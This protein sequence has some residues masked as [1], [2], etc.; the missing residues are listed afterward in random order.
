MTY[1][2][3]QSIADTQLELSHLS[4]Q[5]E[6]EERQRQAD[7][8]QQKIQIEKAVLSSN[9]S[10]LALEEKANE[11]RKVIAEFDTTIK[12]AEEARRQIEFKTELLT[13]FDGLLPN[14]ILRVSEIN[15]DQETVSIRLCIINQGTTRIEASPEF[16][17]IN[18]VE[19][20][21][22]TNTEIEIEDTTFTSSTVIA[23]QILDTYENIYLE[24]PL[25][26]N[27]RIFLEVGYLFS[28]EPAMKD[29]IRSAAKT[30]NI[31]FNESLLEFRSTASFW[32]SPGGAITENGCKNEF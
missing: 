13:K 3:S 25:N 6:T 23:G 7:I 17:T 11:L 4:L 19:Q 20:N 26:K 30:S 5:L 27:E 18:I 24:R 14:G 32:Y 21:K 28:L 9:E 8:D 12:E 16:A 2:Q 29:L 31:E 15:V 1:I 22:V 10:R